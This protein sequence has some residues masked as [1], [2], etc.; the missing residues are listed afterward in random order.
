MVAESPN[1]WGDRQHDFHRAYVADSSGMSRQEVYWRLLPDE[2]PSLG[3]SWIVGV[4]WTVGRIVRRKRFNT[5]PLLA[6]WPRPSEMGSV[7]E[8]VFEVEPLPDASEGEGV[9]VGALTR[10]AAL[11]VELPSG[12]VLW[13]TFNPRSLMRLMPKR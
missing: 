3:G 12:E 5:S 7:A 8:I 10:N 2:W 11:C 13:P 6:V 4:A 9:L 1:D